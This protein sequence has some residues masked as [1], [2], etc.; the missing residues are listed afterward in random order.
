[1]TFEE[2]QREIASDRPVII[3]IVNLPFEIEAETYTASNGNTVPIARFEHTWIVTG[4]NS[5]TV[6][7]VDSEWTYNVKLQ[8]LFD[9]WD[10]LG[11]RAIIMR[12]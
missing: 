8:T 6:T 2:L 11:N 4:Y 10:V 1:M 9:R 12:E 5:Y 3:W 7:V